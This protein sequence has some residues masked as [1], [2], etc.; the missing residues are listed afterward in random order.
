MG[1]GLPELFGGF[2]E[3]WLE[4]TRYNSLRACSY[5]RDSLVI[6]FHG[7]LRITMSSSLHFRP[8]HRR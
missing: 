2:L 3:V 1:L 4:M 7:G 8:V 6:S 5:G